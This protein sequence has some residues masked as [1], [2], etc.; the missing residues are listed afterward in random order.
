MIAINNKSQ[1]QYFIYIILALIVGSITFGLLGC[2]NK[3]LSVCKDT[4]NSCQANYSILCNKYDDLNKTCNKEINS[5]SNQ[6][7]DTFYDRNFW[8]TQADTCTTTL[9]N[10]SLST[11]YVG[12]GAL[13]IDVLIA[14]SIYFWGRRLDDVEIRNKVLIFLGVFAFLIAL[15]LVYYHGY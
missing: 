11:K 1:S 2:S 14:L 15:Y 3:D 9:K 10:M 8:R 5:L 13:I 6:L 7:N 12:I 4:L